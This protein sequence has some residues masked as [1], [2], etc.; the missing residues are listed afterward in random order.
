MSDFTSNLTTLLVRELNTFARELDL[1]PDDLVIWKTTP[2]VT[3]SAAN[4]ALHVAGNLQH[5]VG[6][7]LGSTG[8]VRNREVEFSRSAGSRVEVKAEL[9]AAIRVVQQVLPGLSAETLSARY[10]L[11]MVPGKQIET[12]FFLQHLC[13]HASFH[14]G[15][16]GYLRRALTGDARS[17]T[18]VSLSTIMDPA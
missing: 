10:P 18:P 15:Q 13:S 9:D 11:D 3:N 12:G 2:G 16:A 14:L 7:V 5:F 6:A 17:S 1:F 4:L 8:Y